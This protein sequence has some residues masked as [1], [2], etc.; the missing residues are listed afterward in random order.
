MDYSKLH[1]QSIINNQL[2]LTS[3]SFRGRGKSLNTLNKRKL[4]GQDNLLQTGKS[5]TT[6]VMKVENCK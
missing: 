1:E 3:V 4:S 5:E 6:Q 2:P